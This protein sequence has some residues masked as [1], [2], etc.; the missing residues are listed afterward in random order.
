[1]K[2]STLRNHIL[3]T[4]IAANRACT[5]FRNFDFLNAVETATYLIL[6]KFEHIEDEK[7]LTRENII[8]LIESAKKKVAVNS[9]R[10]FPAFQKIEYTNV[11][12]DLRGLTDDE[13]ELYAGCVWLKSRFNLKEFML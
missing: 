8:S 12:S 10:D 9:N 5:Y 1:M 2:S 6:A 13:K 4:L 3:E 11:D 7:D